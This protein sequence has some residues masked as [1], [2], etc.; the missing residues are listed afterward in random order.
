MNIINKQDLE[1][2]SNY[3]FLG[4]ES[5]KKNNYLIGLKWVKEGSKWKQELVT[6]NKQDV[7]CKTLF[8]SLFGLGKLRHITVSLDKICTYLSR[9][10]WEEIK[11]KTD[12]NPEKPIYKAFV[13]VCEVANRQMKH[14]TYRFKPE[15]RFELFKKVSEKIPGV[16]EHYWNPAINGQD[17]I[18]L[19]KYYLKR[20]HEVQ[21]RFKDTKIGILPYRKLTLDEM[22]NIEVGYDYEIFYYTVSQYSPILER[23]EDVVISGHKS[24]KPPYYSIPNEPISDPGPKQRGI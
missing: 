7:S 16:F 6:V 4:N 17:L 8:L 21:L 11:L 22:P 12:R 23:N 10:K 24:P 3:K 20:V 2:L 9:Y 15:K 14:R 18:C 5:N 1:T 13:T 19:Q